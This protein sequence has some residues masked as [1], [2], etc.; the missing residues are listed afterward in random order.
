MDFSLTLFCTPARSYQSFDKQC[1][2]KKWMWKWVEEKREG[3]LEDQ[4][5]GQIKEIRTSI[6]KQML[7]FQSEETFRP[8]AL[9]EAPSFG[10]RLVK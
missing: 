10:N 8:Q 5:K 9:A 1:Y 4:E 7:K 3:E 6:D 2:K